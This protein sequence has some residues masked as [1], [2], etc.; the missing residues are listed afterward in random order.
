MAGQTWLRARQRARGHAREG[1][2][3]G[4]GRAGQRE[5]RAEGRFR[6]WALAFVLI[7]AAI[8]QEPFR[9]S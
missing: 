8:F 5:G 3:A 2:R 1:T 9:A 7:H 6:V 4:E